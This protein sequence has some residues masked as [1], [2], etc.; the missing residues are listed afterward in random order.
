MNLKSYKIILAVLFLFMTLISGAWASYS[1]GVVIVIDGNDARMKA[2]GELVRD[3]VIKIRETN[4]SLVRGRNPL[5]KI[6]DISNPDQAR[7]VHQVMKV[8]RTQLP[9]FGLSRLKANGSFDFFEKGCYQVGMTTPAKTAEKLM[10]W[11]VSYQS[12]SIQSRYQRKLKTGFRRIT[13]DP[14]GAFVFINNKLIGK[15]DRPLAFGSLEPG[16]HKFRIQ[17]PDYLTYEENIYLDYGS[18]TT[19]HK[20]LEWHMG[21]LKLQTKPQVPEIILNDKSLGAPPIEIRHIL[22]GVHPVTAGLFGYRT[23]RGNVFVKGNKDGNYT[24]DVTLELERFVIQYFL[25]TSAEIYQKDTGEGAG[26]KMNLRAL[27]SDIDC[28]LL[29]API[30]FE[31][32]YEEQNAD[33]IIS[34]DLT[35]PDDSLFA[36]LTVEDA[37]TGEIVFQNRG[38]AS[39]PNWNRSSYEPQ[40][41]NKMMVIFRESLSGR[42][43][44]GKDPMQQN[45]LI[46]ALYNKYDI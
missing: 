34:F 27:E 26:K 46:R 31:R 13:T 42:E 36:Q 43:E 3:I 9:F 33:V 11:F 2:Q 25:K 32:V 4:E 18:F 16:E 14:P 38:T 28:T 17:F 7:F 21:S 12:S 5:V 37:G 1:Q 15:T 41:R 22:S 19:L 35:L 39:P 40:W 30:V 45:T 24:T 8:S 44:I 10:N 29:A 20:Q 23:Y 6:Y